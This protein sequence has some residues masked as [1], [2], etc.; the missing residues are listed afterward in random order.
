MKKKN[1]PKKNLHSLMAIYPLTKK[2]VKKGPEI[3]TKYSNDLTNDDWYDACDTYNKLKVKMSKAA[4]LRT[5]LVP[6]SLNTSTKIQQ[7]SFGKMYKKY[8]AK[9]LKPD[10]VKRKRKRK[11]EAIKKLLWDY[12][13]GRSRKY[14]KDKCGLSWLL[15]R[16]KCVKRAKDLGIDGFKA[17][18]QWISKTLK[19]G[20]FT[21]INLHGEG[22]EMSQE[23]FDKVMTP[24]RKELRE[25]CEEKGVSPKCVYNA[26]QT[27]LFYQKLLNSLYVRKGEA[28][29]LK[30]KKQMKD[31][32]RVTVMVT[33]AADGWRAPLAVIGKSKQPQCFNLSKSPMA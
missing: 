33:T 9:E 10:K 15:M 32:T 20:D 2:K 22:E 3:G 12:V 18:P 21:R 1:S 11:F 31:K 25:L 14:V 28:K 17:S 29:T 30:G 5:S 6:R 24:W 7:S 19:R 8:L 27:G 23:Q 13:E 26:D 16:E 4:F